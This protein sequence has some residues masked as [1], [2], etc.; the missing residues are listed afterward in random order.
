MDTPFLKLTHNPPVLLEQ[1]DVIES[2]KKIDPT[3]TCNSKLHRQ[4]KYCRKSAGWGTDHVGSGRCKLHGGC[5]TGP[6]SGTL[7]YS[8]FVPTDLIEKYEEFAL[9]SDKDIKCLNDEIALLRAK[10]AVVESK[11]KDEKYDKQILMYMEEMRRL[12]ETKQKVEEGIKHKIDI[13]VVHS[14][15]DDVIKIIDRRI[16]DNELKKAI[17]VDMRHIHIPDFI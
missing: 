8:D 11:N 5:S 15:V 12:V 3:S 1:K 9:E 13:S 7:R 17:A 6:K 2:F 4:L 16:E 14:V 10:I